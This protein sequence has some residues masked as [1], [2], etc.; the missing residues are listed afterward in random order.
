MDELDFLFWFFHFSENESKPNGPPS[1]KDDR[2]IVAAL[3][4]KG[5]NWDG[6]DSGPTFSECTNDLPERGT[7]PSCPWKSLNAISKLGPSSKMGPL[8]PRTWEG[9]VMKKY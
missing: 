3:A 4:A 1:P 8:V 7:T 2:L 5:L 9:K 6:A